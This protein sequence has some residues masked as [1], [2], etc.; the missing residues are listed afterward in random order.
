LLAQ[1]DFEFSRPAAPNAAGAVN[2]LT[3]AVDAFTE[4][5]VRWTAENVR[6]AQAATASQ[7]R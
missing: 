7:T 1:R 5:L 6:A 2:S 4:E 3:A